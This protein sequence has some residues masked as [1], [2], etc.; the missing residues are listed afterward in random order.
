MQKPLLAAEKGNMNIPSPKNFLKI[1]VNEVSLRRILF[2]VI[3][4]LLASGYA[5]TIAFRAMNQAS[6]AD[7]IAGIVG[8]ALWFFIGVPASFKLLT[9][10][11]RKTN[12]GGGDVHSSGS[13]LSD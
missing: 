10:R 1:L 11:R 3:V 5:I 8:L 6:D 7:Y 2:A 12:E 4:I 9:Y 13:T